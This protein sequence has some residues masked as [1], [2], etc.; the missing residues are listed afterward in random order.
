MN[1]FQRR[2]KSFRQ[3]SAINVTPLVD[4]MLVLLIIFMVTAPM[5]T[6][7]V[8]VDLPK[9]S[10]QVLSEKEKPLIVSID[11]KG[12]IFMQDLPV[13]MDDLLTKLQTIVGTNK[14]AVV[15]VRGDKKVA[16][17]VVLKVMSL[18]SESG[19]AKVALMA[20][21]PVQ[22]ESQRQSQKENQIKKTQSAT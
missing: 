22:A 7:G 2:D 14:D 9:A 18:I 20:E 19:L 12:N 5:M 15:Y 6:V 3:N 10:G 21:V 11:E 4:V 13:S 17:E 8:K 1:R 16:Y